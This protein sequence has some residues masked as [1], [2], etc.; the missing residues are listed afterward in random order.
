MNIFLTI[1]VIIIALSLAY[2]ETYTEKG[3]WVII[4]I[5]SV[6]VMIAMFIEIAGGPPLLSIIT[7]R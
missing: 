2:I 7:Q 3:G 6:L 1:I 5:F 4:F